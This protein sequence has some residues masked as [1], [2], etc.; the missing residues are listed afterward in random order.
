M[1]NVLPVDTNPVYIDDG[2]LMLNKN[3][4]KG[5]LVSK[6]ESL[7]ANTVKSI[8]IQYWAVGFR[9]YSIDVLRVN[10]AIDVDPVVESSSQYGNGDFSMLNSIETRMIGDPTKEHYLKL[11]SANSGSVIVSFF[12]DGILSKVTSSN[13]RYQQKIK[14]L[15]G[16]ALIAYYPLDETSGNVALDISGNGHNGSYV[17][18]ALAGAIN[19]LTGKP[20]PVWDG[21]IGKYVNLIS[22][23]IVPSFDEGTAIMLVKPDSDVMGSTTTRQI[24]YFSS[25][26]GY[27]QLAKGSLVNILSHGRFISGTYKPYNG[28]GFIN[29]SEWHLAVVTWSLSQSYMRTYINGNLA[30]AGIPTTSLADIPNIILLGAV[31]ASAQS[32]KG[33]MSDVAILNRAITPAEALSIFQASHGGYTKTVGLIG[34]S[35]TASTNATNWVG[36]TFGNYASGR[37]KILNH[38]VGGQ[39]IMTDMDTQR[40]AAATDNADMIILALG[41]NDNNSGNMATLQAKVESNIDAL[42]VSNPNATLYYLNVLPRFDG[43]DKANIRTAIAAACAAKSVACWDTVTDPW[44]VQADTSDNL[45]PTAPGHVKITT[46]ILARLP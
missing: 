20:A 32:W 31:G 42:R 10:F 37:T 41:T 18:V 1:R 13:L 17:G 19:P 3:A 21:S 23:G 12:G 43:A 5:E 9:I 25:P 46:Q 38:A 4:V 29:S 24:F 36:Y 26:N 2:S 39:S 16:D 33:S 6:V 22:S 34:D 27:V 44:I 14:N 15:F 8:F 45:H 35:I 7:T 11:I 28:F 30:V 40:T